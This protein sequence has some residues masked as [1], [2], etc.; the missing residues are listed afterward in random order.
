MNPLTLGLT[1]LAI[2][3]GVPG[4]IASICYIIDRKKNERKPS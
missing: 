3:I 4:A 2:A 1:I